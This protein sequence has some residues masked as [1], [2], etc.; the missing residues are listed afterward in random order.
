[1][2]SVHIPRRYISSHPHDG[3]R[4]TDKKE[5][6]QNLRLLGVLLTTEMCETRI[7]QGIGTRKVKNLAWTCMRLNCSC[8]R[9]G[10]TL[11]GMN[12]MRK[13]NHTKFSEQ[14]DLLLN[15]P[16]LT[17]SIRCTWMR[18][19]SPGARRRQGQGLRCPPPPVSCAPGSCRTPQ[20]N[21]P[22]L[23][24]PMTFILLQCYNVY[25]FCPE[26][27]PPNINKTRA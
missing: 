2:S 1:M 25:I 23:W 9:N 12:V 6:R 10:N 4:E 11:S 14:D 21:S 22:L 5:K 7:P 16:L 17:L 8:H 3:R 27:Q 20:Q 15:K 19:C 24:L 26:V 13:T 18:G